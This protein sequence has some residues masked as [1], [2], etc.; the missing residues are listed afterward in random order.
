MQHGRRRQWQRGKRSGKDNMKGEGCKCNMEG[1][2]GKDNM[3]AVGSKG[4]MKGGSNE[5]MERDG[6]KTK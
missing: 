1:D 2:R 4:N 5:N 3:E 6:V